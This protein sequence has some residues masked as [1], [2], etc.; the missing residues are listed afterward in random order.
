MKPSPFKQWQSV[1]EFA[2][3]GLATCLNP[4][5]VVLL[6]LLKLSFQVLWAIEDSATE[7]EAIDPPI[8]D[9]SSVLLIKLYL[10]QIS[11]AIEAE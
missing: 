10:F 2:V 11:Q 9:I 1:L 6:F 4:Q 7:E 3:V 5:A 8:N